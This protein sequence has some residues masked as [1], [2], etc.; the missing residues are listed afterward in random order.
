MEGDSV[1]L[2][3]G[4]P[5]LDPSMEVYRMG[6]TSPSLAEFLMEPRGLDS[7]TDVVM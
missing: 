2:L 1:A 6:R 5:S 3:R 4:S 7:N